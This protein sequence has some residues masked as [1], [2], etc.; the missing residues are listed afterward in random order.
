VNTREQLRDKR[1]GHEAR[2]DF[3]SGAGKAIYPVLLKVAAAQIDKQYKLN[4]YNREN[5][6]SAPSVIAGTHQ[7]HEDARNYL[8]AIGK[9]VNTLAAIDGDSTDADWMQLEL[10]GVIPTLRGDDELAKTQQK[11][12]YNEMVKK[13]MGGRTLFACP[14]GTY[15]PIYNDMLGL[16]VGSSVG[17]A[18]ETDFPVIPAVGIY[19]PGDDLEIE[20]SHVEFGKPFIPSQYFNKD[21]DDRPNLI[22]AAEALRQI[23]LEMKIGLNEKYNPG[24]TQEDYTA[25]MK[26][27]ALRYP[28]DRD[29]FKNARF[30][31]NYKL[32]TTPEE[33]EAVEQ[34]FKEN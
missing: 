6:P 1:A 27:Q 3:L 2:R 19:I 18:H 24:M 17:V 23:M 15:N 11:A 32:A 21:L 34:M 31:L 22:V 14:E 12:A 20:A 29:Y 26:A 25:F 5:I 16:W 28:N 13:I 4:V 10:T 9:Q 30:S 33:K 7:L 8:V